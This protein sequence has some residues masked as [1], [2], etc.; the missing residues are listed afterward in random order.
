VS[1]SM[2]LQLYRELPTN[3]KFRRQW[4]ALVQSMEQSEVFYTWEWA[5]GVVRSSQQIRPLFFAAYREQTLAGVVALEERGDVTFLTAPTADYCD[6]V[7]SPDDRREFVELVLG[8]LARLNLGSMKLSNIPAASQTVRAL[9]GLTRSSGF[10]QFSRPAYTCAQIALESPEQRTE[11]ATV[12]RNSPKRTARLSRLGEISIEHH[13]N[14]E[15]FSGEFPNFVN[16]HVA[17]FVSQG[18]ISSLANPDRRRFVEELGKLLSEQ[19]SLRC[20][21][22]RLSGRPVAWHFGMAFH[23]KWFWYQPAFDLDYDQASPGTYLLR[24]VIREAAL[25]PEFRAVDL[26]LGNESYKEQYS[27]SAQQTLHFTLDLSKLRLAREMSRYYTAQALKRSP[28][29]EKLARTATANV[30]AFRQARKKQQRS[31]STGQLSNECG[32]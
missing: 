30:E 6:F 7:S 25:S 29:L 27:N 8:E 20:S 1:S 32:D 23:G 15:T 12:A 22:L 9:Q 11:A 4:N 10:A 3:E 31:G 17:R 24:E 26:G 13:T 16:A 14:W 5:A 18:R 28:R 2:R 19:G 21:V